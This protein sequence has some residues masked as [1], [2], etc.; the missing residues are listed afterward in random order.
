MERIFLTVA[1]SLLIGLGGGAIGAYILF[2]RN[3]KPAAIIST[4]QI[5][6]EEAEKTIKAA[7]FEILE[8]PA[9]RTM[10]TLVDGRNYFGETI[11]DFLATKEKKT[12]VIKVQDSPVLDFTEPSFRRL[13][14]ECEYVF[15]PHGVITY[16]PQT[17]ELHQVSFSSPRKSLQ[18]VIFQYLTI[19]V[20]I[21]VIVA[22]IALLIALKLY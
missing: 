15:K 18:E 21:L 17:K 14:L 12:Y 22:I 6:L 11:A 16:D 13:L 10:L 2:R 19:G 3:Q 1:I 9:K 4:S 20:I 7:G 5:N 8:K